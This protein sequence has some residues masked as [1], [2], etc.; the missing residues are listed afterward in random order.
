MRTAGYPL[1]WFTAKAVQDLPSP[2]TIESCELLLRQEKESLEKRMGAPV[3]NPSKGLVSLRADL[4]AYDSGD[5]MLWQPAVASIEDLLPGLWQRLTASE[6]QRWLAG[7]LKS[8]WQAL[9]NPMCA[10]SARDL[11]GLVA[12]GRLDVLGGLRGVGHADG[13]FELQ[14]AGEERLR[15]D[16][17]VDA[18]GVDFEVGKSP[19]LLRQLLEEGVVQPDPAG[20]FA[21]DPAT[22][23]AAGTRGSL[24]VAGHLARGAFY[25][26]SG[27]GFCRA[28]LSRVLQGLRS[29]L[30][31]KGV[32]VPETEGHSA[33]CR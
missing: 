9:A 33:V 3:P 16:Q 28:M 21:L 12:E 14:F 30:R 23:R 26:T 18:T 7:P 20:G 5:Q 13:S 15:V 2:V 10:A 32:V 22:L 11:L 19:G 1:A 31:A 25:T 17:V 8:P 6:K 4:A 27:L 24:F 29:D